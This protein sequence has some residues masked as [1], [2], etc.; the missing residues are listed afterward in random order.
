MANRPFDRGE[1]WSNQYRNPTF[2]YEKD[3]EVTAMLLA[4]V[5]KMMWIGLI[6]V[7]VLAAMLAFTGSGSAALNLFAIVGFPL[8]VI[9]LIG[10]LIRW[11]RSRKEIPIHW[12]HD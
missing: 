6:I 3:Q 11:R 1:R 5:R 8:L 4:D 2:D 12:P 10:E 7:A 9:L